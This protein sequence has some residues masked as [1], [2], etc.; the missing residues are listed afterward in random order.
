[1]PDW[2][3]QGPLD[4]WAVGSV[5]SGCNCFSFWMTSSFGCS[6][7]FW[8]FSS[9]NFNADLTFPSSMSLEKILDM[10]SSDLC[11][12]DCCS[13]FCIVNECLYSSVNL[14]SFHSF[15][16]SFVLLFI[17]GF[18]SIRAGNTMI[19]L[20]AIRW[21]I[22]LLFYVFNHSVQRFMNDIEYFKFDCISRTEK[23]YRT[24]YKCFHGHS[25]YF[26]L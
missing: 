11:F 17:D 20:R 1:M 10:S 12:L 2:L 22:P 14:P 4:E 21:Y 15:R 18:C 24:L 26:Y 7:Q 6:T 8:A 25:A 5:G 23:L 13:F 16:R 9:R 19:T 3:L